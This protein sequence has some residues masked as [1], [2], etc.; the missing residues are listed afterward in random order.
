MKILMVSSY[1]PHPLTSGGHIRL[2][3]LIKKLAGKH[4]I[5]LICEI[6]S[7]QF[8]EDIDAVKKYC[9]EVITVPRK[10]QWSMGNILRAGFSL[11][12]FLVSGHTNKQLK[13]SIFQALTN[14]S[15]DL[16][17]VETFYVSN[18]IPDT[19]V[20]IVLVEHNIE[21]LVYKRFADLAPFFIRPLLYIDV[22][23]LKI[24]E[25]KAWSRAQ[26]LIAVSEEEKQIMR[27]PDVVVIPNGVDLEA[28]NFKKSLDKKYHSAARHLN[29]PQ[30]EILFIGDFKW[31]QNRD[32]VSWILKDI[33]P[34][35]LRALE[36]EVKI[37]LTI[38]GK[39]IPVGIKKLNIFDS[40]RF[41][42][43]ASQKT[44]EIFKSADILLAPIRVGGGTSYKILEAM[45]SGVP[46]VTT[47]RG[48]TGLDVV[49]DKHIC[50]A[51]DVQ[52][53]VDKAARLLR[54]SEEH[55]KIALN[56]RK[57][58]EEK[59]SWDVIIKKLDEVY[60]YLVNSK[61]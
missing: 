28:F 19:S 40:V 16:I 17:H 20:P 33:W 50:V 61:Q 58:I 10:K 11:N 25:E 22:H 14:E 27:K 4:E 29:L 59:Y 18:N 55:K 36:E 47:S 45:A 60:T 52:G 41:D 23:K 44:Y 54:D 31:I 12:S 34:F 7:N 30:K 6:R 21:Y 53:I 46:V 39:N 37:N 35:L 2:F 9:K 1:L 48:V 5:T 26:K 24:N 49:S 56:A 51:D 43:N 57:L 13:K 3:N 32:S 8:Q 38:V 15:Y 42:E